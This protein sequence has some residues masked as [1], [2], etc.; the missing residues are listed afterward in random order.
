MKRK[1][2][3]VTILTLMATVFAFAG[4]AC[5]SKPSTKQPTFYTVS[6]DTLGGNDIPSVQVEQ[7][8]CIEEPE[9]PVKVGYDFNCWYYDFAEFDFS[10]PVNE[11]MELIANWSAKTDV[12]YSIN[13]FV[14]DEDKTA[15]YT[16]FF[17]VMKA[18]TGQ[19]V[20]VSSVATKIL[21]SLSGYYL[22]TKNANSVVEATIA[23]DGSTVF[24]LYFEEL[25]A[26]GNVLA[27][28]TNALEGNGF[29][30]VL[31]NE[32]GYV[33]D[34][35][36]AV[37]KLTANEGMTEIP[38][39]VV[40]ENK[41]WADYDYI[42]YYVYNASN[43]TVWTNNGHVLFRNQWNLVTV[44]L[45]QSGIAD[46]TN[47]ETFSNKILCQWNVVE[48]G[49][50]IDPDSVFYIS[51][52]RGQNFN[53]E[54]TQDDNVAFKFEEEVGSLPRYSTMPAADYYYLTP[55]QVEIG[56]Q[57]HNMTRVNISMSTA[58]SKFHTIRLLDLL[59]TDTSIRGFSFDV[60]NENDFA[61][62]IAGNE[63]AAKT[64][65]TIT[66]RRSQVE[67]FGPNCFNLYAL[68]ANDEYLQAG[69]SYCIGN[70]VKNPIGDKMVN[71]TV[72]AYVQN[73]P[74]GS[75][76]DKSAEFDFGECKINEFGEVNIQNKAEELT[77]DNHYLNTLYEGS[78]THV[79]EVVEGTQFVIYYTYTD[80]VAPNYYRIE[81]RGQLSISYATAYDEE[82]C[83]YKI[84]DT[85]CWT[86]SE[87][88]EETKGTK[89][90]F[91]DEAWQ[92]YQNALAQNPDIGKVVF[93]VMEPTCGLTNCGGQCRLIDAE[94]KD[95]KW[96]IFRAPLYKEY[97]SRIELT[98]EQFT[99]IY[100][101]YGYYIDFACWAEGHYVY[102][103]GLY[104]E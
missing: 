44:E 31:S 62:Y 17:G 63:I 68:N 30:A 92:A 43:V 26:E 81:G 70:V 9:T 11:D 69:A 40:P 47:V 3:L 19:T 42:S 22:D 90:Y 61:I 57:T 2:L 32:E 51:S 21:E 52:I 39:N 56:N 66:V 24:N 45:S 29:T 27:C 88:S 5:K 23:G 64:L 98:V 7:G 33:R 102:L 65:Q 67:F 79:Y 59:S 20:N 71:Y 4:V 16:D 94:Q 99:K 46:I 37:L 55:A 36:Q 103:S 75:Y 13:V 96:D 15:D 12:A 14:S 82:V 101:G 93:Y 8:Q 50:K 83:S 53:N 6:F 76:E 49:M 74:D 48:A 1:S 35:E 77:P 73:G 72:K 25:V 80:Y 95:G 78:V 85:N 28:Y 84:Y 89:L 38:F 86:D 87:E 100:N 10:T 54:Y 104:F 34:G 41:D 18:T 97:F 91:T 58:E 60:Y